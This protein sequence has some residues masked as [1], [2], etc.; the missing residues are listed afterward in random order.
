M[1]LRIQEG[2]EEIAND[3]YCSDYVGDVTN[4][5]LNKPKP[6]RILYDSQHD[7]WCVG[8]AVNVTHSDMAYELY[9]TG[10][11]EKYITDGE[12]ALIRKVADQYGVSMT[13]AFDIIGFNNGW[14]VGAFFIPNGLEYADYEDSEFYKERFE[15]T[16]G[17]LFFRN[18]SYF[19]NRGVF[20]DLFLKLKQL[21]AFSDSEHVDYS[22][23][24]TILH[25]SGIVYQLNYM[26]NG[27]LV[28]FVPFNL[29]EDEHTITIYDPSVI[30]KADYATVSYMMLDF[31]KENY[32]DYY[33]K[34]RLK[35]IVFASDYVKTVVNDEYVKLANRQRKLLHTLEDLEKDYLANDRW[36]D[37][38]PKEEMDSIGAEW[39]KAYTELKEVEKLMKETPDHFT[40]WA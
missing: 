21:E 37:S 23:Y 4:W 2:L 12:N 17:T 9:K 36:L 14:L 31:L 35:D 32:S 19:T 40:V 33:V 11:V 25:R 27:K 13:R 15:I 22:G 8:N 7:I 5:L 29:L 16:T 6:Y 38:A 1:K 30:S 39:E 3:V 34:L 26:E 28:G 18:K 10:Y 24:M 20:K